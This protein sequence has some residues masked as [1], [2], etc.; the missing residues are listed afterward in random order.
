MISRSTENTPQN[1]IP[2]FIPWT[3]AIGNQ[4]SNSAAMICDDMVGR[5]MLLI[6]M[7]IFA[8]QFHRALDNRYKQV[9]L[10]I[11]MYPLENSCNTLHPHSSINR[12]SGQRC[13]FPL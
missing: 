11:V 8:K 12:W 2:P 3:N 10:V 4:K 13:D 7:A 1:I 9:R 6:V 5:S